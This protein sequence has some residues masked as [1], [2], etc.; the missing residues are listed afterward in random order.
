MNAPAQDCFV[1]GLA[2]TCWEYMVWVQL[3]AGD[4][5]SAPT[6]AFELQRLVDLSESE[7][8][9]IQTGVRQED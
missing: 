3:L 7:L 6:F 8:V 2:D 4:D 5:L 1:L 9:G